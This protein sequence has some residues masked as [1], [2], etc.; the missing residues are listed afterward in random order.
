MQQEKDRKRLLSR[1]VIR[2]RIDAHAPVEIK[3][4]YAV[5]DLT[6]GAVWNSRIVA[7]EILT[8][9]NLDDIL[10]AQTPMNHVEIAG[11]EGVN[12][13]DL[14]EVGIGPRCARG[15]DIGPNSVLAFA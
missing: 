13:I 3:T 7:G 14:D 12:A 2:R 15:G 6:Y 1:S 10:Q 5:D 9:S 11:V 4:G 8:T